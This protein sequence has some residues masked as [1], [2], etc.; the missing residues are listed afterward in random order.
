MV[1]YICAGISFVAATGSL[2]STNLTQILSVCG[3]RFCW[4]R[5]PQ[6]KQT[7]YQTAWNVHRIWPFIYLCGHSF[8]SEPIDLHKDV[9]RTSTRNHYHLCHVCIVSS[10]WE[11]GCSNKWQLSPLAFV[12]AANSDQT[13]NCF[14]GTLQSLSWVF[15]GHGRKHC[16][17]EKGWRCI[18]DFVTHFRVIYDSRS[19]RFNVIVL[20]EVTTRRQPHSVALFASPTESKG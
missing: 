8:L 6:I 1:H 18:L 7:L 19:L 5:F 15:F 16:G 20:A 11:K 9:V 3:Y 10:L 12:D 14:T 4:L 2:Q 13:S 17:M